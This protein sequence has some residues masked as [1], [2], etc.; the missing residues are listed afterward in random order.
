MARL[1]ASQIGKGYLVYDFGNVH[2]FYTEEKSI[3]EPTDESVIGIDENDSFDSGEGFSPVI[4]TG[5]GCNY[6]CDYCYEQGLKRTSLY[7]EAKSLSKIDEFYDEYCRQL[8]VEKKYKMVS[9]IGGEPFLEENRE[10]IKTVFERWP[11]TPICFSTNGV[12]I[13]EYKEM[14]EHQDVEFHISLDGTKAFHYKRRHPKANN[15]Y[16]KTMDGIKWLVANEKKVVIMMLLFKDNKADFSSFLD[17]LEKLG[18]PEKIELVLLPKYSC[19]GEHIDE[20]YLQES[21]NMLLELYKEEPRLRYINIEKFAPGLRAFRLHENTN[22]Y[23][24]DRL[25]GRGHVFFP[26]GRVKICQTVDS[27]V[28]EIGRFLPLPSVDMNKM[29][30][31]IS[32]KNAVIEKCQGCSFNKVCRGGCLAHSVE[33]GGGILDP[34]CDYWDSGAWERAFTIVG[35]ILFCEGKLI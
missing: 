19:G 35:N 8:G 31:I 9:L 29:E 30:L 24:C 12:N 3:N 16:E 4:F 10:L 13:L 20:K 26:D 21:L 14:L 2:V 28:L 5:Y 15:Y 11:N 7:M 25:R 18:W 17:E 27:D 6:S 32:R 22:M 1:F 34:N 23:G 33:N